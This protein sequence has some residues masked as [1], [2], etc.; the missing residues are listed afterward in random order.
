MDSRC[1]SQAKVMDMVMYGM[2]KAREKGKP[3][4][5]FVFSPVQLA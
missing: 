2:C 3:G 4:M 5:M 1:I